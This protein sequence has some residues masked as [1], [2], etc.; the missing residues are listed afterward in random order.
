VDPAFPY[1]GGSI[2]ACG[3]DV[4]TGL[5][6]DPRVYKDLMS[7]CSPRWSSDY[8][9]K[10]ILRFRAAEPLGPAHHALAAEVQDCLLV[11]GGLRHGLA[12][13]D[14]AFQVRRT[15]IPPSPGEY[16]L[17][18][19]DAHGRVLDQVPFAPAEVEDLDQEPGLGVFTLVIPMTQ[20]M[21]KSLATLRV[22]RDGVTL[23]ERHAAGRGLTGEAFTP[24]AT[25]D[26]HGLVH[27]L[28][29]PR[30]YPEV[31]VTDGHSGQVISLGAGGR[32]ALET[33]AQELE[34][35]FSDGL[36]TVVRRVPVQ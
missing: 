16:R 27:L 4:R 35:L 26:G 18:A 6:K 15:P 23:G 31:I 8:D 28:W 20:A 34:C 24:H 22:S 13:L 12:E 9:C 3:F 14:A 5:P 29:D 7:Y 21:K 32:L 17:T 33:R 1:A 11:S 19:L 30:S 2:G 36:R 10:A 25:R